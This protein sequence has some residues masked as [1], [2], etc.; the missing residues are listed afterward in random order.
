MRRRSRSV[1]ILVSLLLM[2][3]VAAPVV[4]Q[5]G[6]PTGEGDAGEMFEPL[7]FAALDEAPPA[8]VLFALLRITYEPGAALPP[9]V[10]PGPLVGII[11][12]G[13][14]AAQPNGP[15]A[16]Q[17]AAAATPGAAEAATPYV[18]LN[19]NEGDQIVTPTG[20]GV[21]YYNVGD[22]P[23]SALVAALLPADAELPTGYPAGI[24][25]RFLASGVMSTLPAAP[26]AV[27]MVRLTYAPGQADPAPSEN[28]G[29]LL[30]AVEAGS[31]GYTLAEGE[32]QVTSGG[33]AGTPVAGA[34]AATPAVPGEE[35]TLV[36]GDAVVE[37]GGAA[38]SARNPGDEPATVL[39]AI[40][41]P[42]AAF[43]EDV[44]TPVAGT[45][46]P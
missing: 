7:A 31:I 9:I 46:A 13:T 44:G 22:G 24:T 32:A 27:G 1:S 20:T 8:P 30:A 3:A 19:L 15:A 25:V 23:A 34:S 29:P 5:E 11:E 45:P 28:D 26:L 2:L 21:A 41:A 38:S 16:V 14:V 36:A 17:R 37:Q 18:E 43:G 6:T 39:I 10:F 12:T 35:V 40:V 42:S 4:A 33:M